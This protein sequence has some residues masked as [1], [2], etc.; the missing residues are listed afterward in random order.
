[1]RFNP[2]DEVII[3]RGAAKRYLGKMATVV[4]TRPSKSYKSS[5]DVRVIMTNWSTT[6]PNN[7]GTWIWNERCFRLATK[8]DRV[9]I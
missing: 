9:L 6:G 5:A 4:E 7:D 8:L 2:G 1:M 3:F